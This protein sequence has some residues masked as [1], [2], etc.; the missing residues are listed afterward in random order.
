MWIDRESGS[1]ELEGFV[2]EPGS[3]PESFESLRG[4]HRGGELG[5]TSWYIAG[6][7]DDFDFA[8]FFRRDRLRSM[9]L[10]RPTLINPVRKALHDS[11]VRSCLGKENLQSRVGPMWGP[12]APPKAERY[13]ISKT[14]TLIWRTCW[15]AVESTFEP[16]D[17]GPVIAVKWRG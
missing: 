8:V 1:L 14:R 4:W 12:F 17:W 16:R 2:F 6:R 10:W 11:L 9:H 13:W 15:G 7:L 3:P 5:R